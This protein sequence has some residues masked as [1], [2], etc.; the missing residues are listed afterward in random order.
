MTAYAELQVTTNFSFLEG[1]SHAE[2]LVQQAV[3]LGLTAIAI[4]DRNTLAGVVR[5]HV[6]ARHTDLK[7]ITAARLE[8]RDGPSAL[9]LPM[10]RAAYGHLSQLITLGR[11]R[12]PKGECWIDWGDLIE[13]IEGQQIILLPPRKPDA[14]FES[15]LAALRAILGNNL[16][17]ALCRLHRSDDRR[18]L[19]E[20]SKLAKG[21]GV[22]TVVTNDVLYHEPGRQ[23][24]QDVLTCIKHGC[25]IDKAGRRLQPNTERYLKSADQMVRLFKDY[26]EAISRSVDIANRCR[27][28]LEELRYEYP[29]ETRGQSAT[30]QEEL[31]R[32]TWEGARGRYP[33]GIP[34]NVR[35][36][37]EHELTLISQLGYAP[38]FLTVHDIVRFARSEGILCQGRGSAANSA[39]CYCLGITSVDPAKMDLLFERFVSAER[40][41]P[42][43]IDVD[44]EHERRE[45]VIQYIY[46]RFGRDKAGLAATVIHYQ[47]RSA[48]REVGKVMGLSIDTIDRMT[49][50]LWGWGREGVDERQISDA[51]I[52]PQADRVRRCLELSRELVG[53]PRHLSQHVGGFIITR[54]P[55]AELV[56]IEN[57]AMA[58]RTVIQWDKDDIDALGILKIDVLALGMLTAIRKA[59]ELIDRHHNRPLTL[60]SVP[61]DD[62]KVYEMLSRADSVGVFQVES[63]AQMTML[64]RLRPRNFYD[65]VIEVAIVRPGPI[66]GDMVHPY[67][68]RRNG[69]E[70]VSYPSK[71]LE[72]VLGKTLGVPLFQE[73]AMKIAIVAG[74]FTPSEADQLRRAMATFRRVGTIGLFQT[75]LIE[76]MVVRGYERDFAERCF[77]QIEGFGEYGFPE[78]HAASFAL[79]VYVSAWIKCHY[80]AAFAA[81]LLNSQPMGFYAPAQLVR[82]ARDHG[83]EVRP[84]DVNTSY[85]N[86]TLEPGPRGVA[87]RLGFRQIKG[88]RRTDAERLS[89]ARQ[90]GYSTIRDLWRRATLS[91]PILELLARADAFGSLGLDRRAALWAIKALGEKPL[92]L[93]EFA[94]TL[95]EPGDNL[96]PPDA[97]FEPSVTL[98]NLTVGEQVVQDYKEL[99]LTLRQHPLA[100]LRPKLRTIGVAQ[101]RDLKTLP[102]NRKVTIAG[103]VLV[104]QRPGTASGVIFATIEDETGVGNIIIW[105]KVFERYRRIVL[106]A[107]LLGVEGVLQR[108]GLVI[109]VIANRLTDHTDMLS[110]LSTLTTEDVF[111]D[112]L[113]HADEVRNPVREIKV[114]MPPSRDF[115]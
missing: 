113:A 55:L 114:N 9:C 18:R 90:E 94:E 88:A 22:A 1:A 86:N 71:E 106:G 105:P 66:Q 61:Q 52:D 34:E 19:A 103:L 93:F 11:R 92:P 20:L 51:G 79:L 107:R 57:A 21:V 39:V 2:E 27:F 25:T 85:W 7:V 70:I 29:E 3:A 46:R 54:G 96:P 62:P 75:K 12:A 36:I 74:G 73:Q 97:A 26:P 30:P 115:R 82:D 84:I 49:R 24:L 37:L 43:D 56:P 53:F 64:P 48:I 87:L 16:S 91:L 78:S 6:A 40:R 67:L 76:G 15:R 35:A 44:F 99:R 69:E 104:R 5:A 89:E 58:D 111:A 28:S 31:V 63:R 80:P 110:E 98:P 10:D 14:A 81:G 33:D 102:D 45:E 72:R 32:L 68:R 65:L 8:F 95:G 13:R 38:Y 109:H 17:L 23:V 42:P 47:P 77:K 83:V 100:L 41:E 101:A 59:F 112:I 50:T 108:E 4:T 60:A